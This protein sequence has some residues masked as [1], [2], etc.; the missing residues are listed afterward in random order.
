MCFHCSELV[1]EMAN[2]PAAI[3]TSW[4]CPACGERKF[5]KDADPPGS[6]V[7]PVVEWV[8]I[9]FLICVA[10]CVCV[11]MYLNHAK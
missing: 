10:V 3:E 9:V 8:P 1:E 5:K 2:S 7:V 6:E 11:G 4:H